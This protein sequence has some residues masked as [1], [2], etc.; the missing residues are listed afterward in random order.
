M[1]LPPF[2]FTAF[3]AEIFVEGKKQDEIRFFYGIRTI[4]FDAERGFF[5]NGVS[6]K[7]KGVCAHHDAGVLGAAVPKQISLP[8]LQ[9][10][11]LG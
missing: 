11:T 10:I 1:P 9:R 6:T 4:E 2:I 8:I 3:P 5:L 7:L